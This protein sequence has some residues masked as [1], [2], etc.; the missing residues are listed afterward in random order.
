MERLSVLNPQELSESAELSLG[1]VAPEILQARFKKVSKLAE[2]V[3][4]QAAVKT[5]HDFRK[6]SKRFRYSLEMVSPAYGKPAK[7]VMRR[8]KRLQDGVGAYIDAQIAID[9]L[10]MM[11]DTAPL[12]TPSSELAKDL[13]ELHQHRADE[14]IG[15]LSGPWKQI[16]GAPWKK[17]KRK[18]KRVRKKVGV[19]SK[20]QGS[21]T[22]T[23]VHGLTQ[24]MG[25]IVVS[26]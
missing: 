5:V 23:E 6:S 16:E 14:T 20:S 11:L 13:I 19:E 15:N 1:S 7:R 21:A 24:R 17:L 2:E 18:M 25:R 4:S 26:L 12:D 22:V 8:L 9:R 10:R 3:H